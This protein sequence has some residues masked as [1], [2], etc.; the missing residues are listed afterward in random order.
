MALL[1]QQFN[2]RTYVLEVDNHGNMEC[3][4]FEQSTHTSY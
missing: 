1:N 4:L 3:A 2:S